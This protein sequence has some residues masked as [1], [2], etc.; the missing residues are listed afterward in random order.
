MVEIYAFSSYVSSIYLPIMSRT[1]FHVEHFAQTQIALMFH[2][3]HSSNLSR[4]C[5]YE[6]SRFIPLSKT[7]FPALRTHTYLIF[8]Y[9]NPVLKGAPGRCSRPRAEEW[10]WHRSVRA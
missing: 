7:N 1:M 4:Q 10:P 6:P 2:V 8:V 3:E 5:A 9:E